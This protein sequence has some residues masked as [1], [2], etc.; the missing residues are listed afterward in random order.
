MGLTNEYYEKISNVLFNDFNHY[1]NGS[2]ILDDINSDP[3]TFIEQDINNII[4]IS[5]LKDKH[6]ILECGC[7][8][9]Y[10]FNHLIKKL[11]NISY[12][13]I[14][15]S[16]KQINNAKVLNSDTKA[17]FLACDWHNLPFK[18]NSFDRILFLETIGYAWDI[19]KL[20]SECYRVLKPNGVIFSKHPGLIKSK[21]K[22]LSINNQSFL[23]DI[24]NEYGYQP[25]SLGMLMDVEYTIEKFKENGFDVPNNY[26]IPIIDESIYIKKHFIPEFR[27]FITLNR[28]PSRVTTIF[29]SPIPDNFQ[30]KN[31]VSNFG[32]MHPNLVKLFVNNYSKNLD[33]FPFSS[34]ILI[35]AIKK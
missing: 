7:G 17:S 15:L 29:P 2:L 4:K 9:G 14:D 34:C 20:L 27:E 22:S 10:F 26:Q 23:R 31:I 13:G 21:L 6:K 25:D 12:T 3:E 33:L 11:P 5:N 30:G 24:E 28:L 8:N 35:T 1:Y 16:E 32:M 18:D 19:D